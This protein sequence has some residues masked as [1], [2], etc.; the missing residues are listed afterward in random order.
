[1]L[2]VESIDVF[3]GNIQA[4]RGMDLEVADGEMVALVGPNGAGKTT[5]LRTISGLMRP[6][7]GTV[8]FDGHRIDEVP[9]QR[10]VEMGIAQVPEGRGVFP[11][12]TV[13]ENLR[14]G[15]FV[16][17]RNGWFREG[18]SLVFDLFPRLGERKGQLAAT[19]SGGE[20]QMLA[21]GRA[22]LSRPKLLL[23]DEPSLGLAPLVVQQLF[24]ILHD[25]NRREGTAMLLVEQFVNLALR[26]TSRTY[27]LAKGEVRLVG[28]SSD[29]MRDTDLVR[30]S[31]LGGKSE[32]PP[33][34]ARPKRAATRRTKGSPGGRA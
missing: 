11:S 17:R 27:V 33:R 30:A 23:I 13:L 34:A 8:T 1:M 28:R 3:Y 31:Y 4:L 26:Y 25:I 5:T 24:Q 20:Q 21:M 7:A 14:M 29:L 19:L 6:G 9:P 18:L 32:A 16:Q 22:L 2:S 12:L 10:I 15:H